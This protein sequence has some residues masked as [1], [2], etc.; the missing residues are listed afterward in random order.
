VEGWK[1]SASIPLQF[2]KAAK[3][4]NLQ[5]IP[6]LREYH[7]YFVESIK[8]ELPAS[9]YSDIRFRKNVLTSEKDLQN[10]ID[11]T[12]N[13]LGG[14]DPSFCKASFNFPLPLMLGILSTP[15]AATKIVI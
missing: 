5:A 7:T 15:L 12:N 2:T 14:M 6:V 11:L 3:V 1:Q 13:S 8:P 10:I 4:G 9:N